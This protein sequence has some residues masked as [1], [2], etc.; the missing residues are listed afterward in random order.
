[1]STRG[2]WGRY[3]TIRVVKF[4]ALEPC[5]CLIYVGFS[6]L[7]SHLMIDSNVPFLPLN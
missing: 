4:T 7:S 1:M 2:K 5:V 3:F 6:S